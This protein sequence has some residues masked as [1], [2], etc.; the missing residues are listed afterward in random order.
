M[1]V[2][3]NDAVERERNK[4]GFSVF[5]QHQAGFRAADLGERRRDR[6]WHERPLRDGDLQIG[7]PARGRIHQIGIEKERRARQ[8]QRGDFRLIGGERVHDHRRCLLAAAQRLGERPAHQW[9]RIIKQH[10]HGAFGG[11]Q[12]IG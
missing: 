2:A 10:D 3:D 9:R 4:L 1:T 6:A 11:G 12:I 8:H 7:L 5:Q